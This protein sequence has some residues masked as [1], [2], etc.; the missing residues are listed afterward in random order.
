MQVDCKVTPRSND[1]MDGTTTLRIRT[2]D[3]L[4]SVQYLDVFAVKIKENNYV[5]RIINKCKIDLQTVGSFAKY[6]QLIPMEFT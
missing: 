6:L 5:I 2:G 3:P 4:V 1:T